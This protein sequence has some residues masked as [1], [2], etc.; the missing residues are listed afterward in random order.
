M[1]NPLIDD[2]DSPAFSK[3]ESAARRLKELGEDVESHLRHALEKSPS[4]EKRKR[5]TT[6]LAELDPFNPPA[7]ALAAVRAVAAL[8]K[9][10]TPEAVAALKEIEAGHAPARL[11]REIEW[12]LQRVG[13]K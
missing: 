9:A 5:L 13:K 1:V 12:A 4:A 3:R 10:G 7:D 2:L 11:Q 8:E 6:L